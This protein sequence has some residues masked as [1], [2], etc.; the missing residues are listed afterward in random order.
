MS[1]A[2]RRRQPRGQV[3][4]ENDSEYVNVELGYAGA[5]G[6]SSG[7]QGTSNRYENMEPSPDLRY[8]ARGVDNLAYG[9][10]MG[11]PRTGY[12]GEDIQL[13]TINPAFSGSGQT[14]LM[15]R[16][17]TPSVASS[18][19][20]Q[21]SNDDADEIHEREI[22]AASL[23]DP[24]SV[25]DML[26]SRQLGHTLHR[27][28]SHHS[29]HHSKSM[30]KRSRS[31]S[32]SLRRSRSTTRRNYEN[33]NLENMVDD[34]LSDPVLVEGTSRGTLRRRNTIRQISGTID[35]RR[36]VRDA[37]E[38]IVVMKEQVNR[39]SSRTKKEKSPGICTAWFY[40]VAYKWE[41]FLESLSD[42][43][44]SLELW[45]SSIKKI[46]GNFGSGVTSYFLLLKWLL[47]LN[48]PVFLL[49][50]GFVTTPQL[51][52]EPSARYPHSENFS[53]WD[54]LTGG[55]WF[56]DTELYCGYYTNET[57]TVDNKNYYSMPLAYLITNI[58]IF[59]LVLIVI[60]QGM[61]KAYRQYFVTGDRHYNFFT[62]KVFCGW[63]Y[64]ITSE[65]TSRL[66]NKSIYLE[67][68]EALT[69]HHSSDSMSC[70]KQFGIYMLRLTI[71]IIVLAI[72]AG[73]SYL[74]HFMYDSVVAEIDSGLTVVRELAI[75]L[76]ISG[77]NL[78]LPYMFSVLSSFE[79][80]SNPRMQLYVS[81]FRTFLMKASVLCVLCYFWLNQISCTEESTQNCVVCWET[82][83]GT[84]VYKLV[85][86][87]F[88]LQSLATFVLEFIR[89]IG[90]DHC[91]QSF[92]SPEFDIA[93]N[94]MDLIQSQT[95]TW[96]GMYFSPLLMVI[97]IFKLVLI[98]YVKKVSV[99]YNCKPSLRP[100]KAGLAK[101]V[102]LA[103]LFLMFMI[104]LGAFGYSVVQIEPSAS[105]GPFRGRNATYDVVIDLFGKWQQSDRVIT[106]IVILLTSP[107]VL[108]GIILMI[109]LLVYYRRS[110][111]MGYKETVKRLQHQINLEGKDKR[112]LLRMLQDAIKKRNKKLGIT[113][114]NDSI[115]F[116]NNGRAIR[117]PSPSTASAPNGQHRSPRA[118]G[119]R[120]HKHHHHHPHQKR[121]GEVSPSSPHL[122]PR[123]SPRPSPRPSPRSSRHNMGAQ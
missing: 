109:I 26:P 9:S 102:F 52:Y 13:N 70:C 15:G 87:D 4:V 108:I 73:A 54:L 34:I 29:S 60:T 46:E 19:S 118:D 85:I 82:F 21:S 123:L 12:K 74:V 66:K 35:T 36:R 79:K 77:Y 101:T 42:F 104:C 86:V 105:C 113:N 107:G 69:T 16:S 22:I 20:Y 114:P 91:C 49:T 2:S 103:I 10:P 30:R 80:Y 39:R 55:G 72:I 71:N 119:R 97:N 121:G 99:L 43:T 48:I 32:A 56:K 28:K 88:I 44:Y 98:F 115:L 111:A 3:G 25:I 11:T 40:E 23:S 33:V 67:L 59:I 57:F 75:P 17:R 45:R 5:S 47:L 117:S 53:G 94:T 7:P 112:F 84:E 8:G 27:A 95:Y 100:W 93:R 6:Y 122:S 61:S 65:S 14:P 68:A 63:D 62:A 90:K 81:L 110:V 50:F 37:L 96:I 116:S 24:N 64:S 38:Y 83:I 31:R 58:L 51:I 92:A 89:R 1:S 106:T 76:V 120:K 78:M 18:V 41:S